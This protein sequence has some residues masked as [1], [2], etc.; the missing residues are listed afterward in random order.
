MRELAPKVRLKMFM[1]A[2]AN[3]WYRFGIERL[4]RSPHHGH[5]KS[6]NPYVAHKPEFPYPDYDGRDI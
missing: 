6:Y 4:T 3:L 1:L 2:R 5:E